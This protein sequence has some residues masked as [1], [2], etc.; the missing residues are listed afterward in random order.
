[1]EDKQNNDLDT[2]DGFVLFVVIIIVA[3]IFCKVVF[4][5]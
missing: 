1:M 3:L 5:S 4:P 2:G